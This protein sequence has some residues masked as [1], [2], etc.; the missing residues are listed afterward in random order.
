MTKKQGT[1]KRKAEKQ[2]AKSLVVVKPPK[3]T[4]FK[5]KFEERQL[6]FLMGRTPAQHIYKR[7]AKGVGG[8][9]D[10]VTGVY[11]QKVLNYVFG[12]DWDFQIIDKGREEN[13]VWVQGRLTVR[14]KRGNAIV[15]EQFGRAEIKFKR[16]KTGMLD[17]GNDLKSAATD[18]L[19]KCASELGIASDVYG[20]NE[21]KEI[22]AKKVSPDQLDPKVETPVMNYADKIR[23]IAK[24]KGA[25]SDEAVVQFIEM[26]T[27]QIVKDL[28]TIP[29]TRA[30]LILDKLLNQ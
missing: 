10:Y 11:V 2:S 27:G 4:M 30:K 29:E 17:Y 24:A 26:R 9:W 14:D 12:W 3:I 13:L 16:D 15:K 18:S 1:A 19:K 20:K 23:M 22:G 28:S 21:F 25:D 5:S 7:P 6:A 8:E